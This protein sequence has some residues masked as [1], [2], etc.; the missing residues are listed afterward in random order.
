MHDIYSL[1]I[2]CST[3]TQLWFD[4]QNVV[5]QLERWEQMKVTGK[6]TP[7]ST[8]NYRVIYDYSLFPQ[9]SQNLQV[10]ACTTLLL[11]STKQPKRVKKTLHVDVGPIS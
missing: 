11:S 5:N 6:F 2:H 3:K 8:S 9:H 10:R 1:F 4:T 7:M